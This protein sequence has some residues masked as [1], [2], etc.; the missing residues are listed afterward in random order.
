MLVHLIIA[1][2]IQFTQADQ[3]QASSSPCTFSCPMTNIHH[4]PLFKHDFAI[5]Y[6]SSYYSVFECVYS[7]INAN[8]K[9]H[10]CFYTKTDGKQTLAVKPN[11]CHSQAIPCSNNPDNHHFSSSSEN[12]YQVPAW[13]ESGR[14]LLY[15]KENPS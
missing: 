14:Y 5:P 8:P 7:E 9:A 13:V 1:L 11:N 10:S 4:Q 12:H 3:E 6:D 15:L 2:A